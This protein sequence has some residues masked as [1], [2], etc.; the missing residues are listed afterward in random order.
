MKLVTYNIHRGTG[1][2]NNNTLENMIDY[3]NKNEIDILC[4]Q[5]VLKSQHDKI[6]NSTNFKG[7]YQSNVD[8]KNDKYGISIY[9]KEDINVH[10]VEGNLLTSKKEQRSFLNAQLYVN[11]KLLNIINTHLGLDKEE[12][13][14]QIKE[15]LDEDVYLGTMGTK[16]KYEILEVIEPK[17]DDK[18]LK[19]KGW[20]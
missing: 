3:F 5:E 7:C 6:L 2:K 14:T 8:L 17:E 9:Y 13:K 19:L 10:Y 12:R 1:I 11:N 4:L 16:I 18:Q 15:I 20:K